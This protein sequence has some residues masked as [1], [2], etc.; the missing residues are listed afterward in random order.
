[1][2]QLTK[3]LETLAAK[4]G[5]TAQYLWAV[6]IK[7]ARVDA[8]ID[9][10]LLLLSGAVV[11]ILLRLHLRFSKEIAGTHQY[12]EN[13]LYQKHGEMLVG[14]MI[15][16]AAIF[17]ILFIAQLMCVGTIVSGFLNPEYWALNK[18]LGQLK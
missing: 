10:L 8:T 1:M 13:T 14:P 3:L 16:G 5:T 6:L 2:E 15:L 12:N 7:Q 17:S 11:F 4:L 9:L 18:V